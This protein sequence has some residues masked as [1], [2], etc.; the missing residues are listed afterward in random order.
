MR[1]RSIGPVPHSRTVPGVE[2]SADCEL[3]EATPFT[4]WFHSDD[5][6][7][8]A[9]CDSCGVPMVVWREHDPE[10]PAD[11]KASLHE[12]LSAV[13]DARGAGPFWIDDRLRSIPDHYHAHARQRPDW[14]RR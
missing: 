10:P 2:R 7:W 14:T 13:M 6:C 11:V 3:C 1:D 5:L 4:E 12:R 8:I 9:E